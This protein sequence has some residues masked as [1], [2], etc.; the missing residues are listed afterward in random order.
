MALEPVTTKEH[1]RSGRPALKIMSNEFTE[2]L[3]GYLEEGMP[4]KAACD[5][6][7]VSSTSVRKYVRTGLQDLAAGR[8]TV[9]ADFGHNVNRAMAEA[10]HKR[11]LQLH[12]AADNPMF[13]TAAAWWLERMYPQE[14]GKQDRLALTV[15]EGNKL[16]ERLKDVIPLLSDA[17]ADALGAALA[18]LDKTGSESGPHDEEPFGFSS[19]FEPE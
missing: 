8:E 13:W 6:V 10:K 18:K 12:K 2:T 17:E 5:L 15:H 7:G 9:L 4:F 3:I 16:T 11:I 14:F 19:E 1:K